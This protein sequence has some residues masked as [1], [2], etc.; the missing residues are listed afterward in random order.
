MAKAKEKDREKESTLEVG[1][2][3]W[4]RKDGCQ[5]VYIGE[6]KACDV[7]VHAMTGIETTTKHQVLFSALVLTFIYHLFDSCIY[8]FDASHS[9]AR[10]KFS[11]MRR[12]ER[13]YR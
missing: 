6:G 7:V 13:V 9:T 4:C 3:E 11:L 12:N 8:P 10:L 2:K 1:D 5:E